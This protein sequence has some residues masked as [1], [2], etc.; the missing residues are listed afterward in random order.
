MHNTLCPVHQ[1]LWARNRTDLRVY[2][3]SLSRLEEA[4]IYGEY[5]NAQERAEKAR[6]T[7]EDSRDQLRRHVR[8][9]G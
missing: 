2:I 1:E 8:E 3:D 9:H 6:G 7:F 4:Y 5:H